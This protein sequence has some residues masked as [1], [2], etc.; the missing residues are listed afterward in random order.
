MNETINIEG[1][2]GTTSMKL[3][4]FAAAASV[5]SL[6]AS[7]LPEISEWMSLVCKILSAMA[8]LT[9]ITLGIRKWRRQNQHRKGKH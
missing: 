8:S 5:G 4:L 1:A 6:I 2:E 3:I 9:V 7:H